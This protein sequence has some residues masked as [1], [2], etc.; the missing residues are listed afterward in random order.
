MV[1]Y[2]A[3][4]A[5]G[6]TPR[7]ANI[8]ARRRSV[9]ECKRPKSAKTITRWARR[10]LEAGGIEHAPLETYL[11]AKSSPHFRARKTAKVKAKK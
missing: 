7:T 11:D 10:V 5:S 9:T 3:E 2:F 4:L 8:E 6:G 1:S